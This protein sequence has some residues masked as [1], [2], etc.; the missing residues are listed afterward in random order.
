LTPAKLRPILPDCFIIRQRAGA[1]PAKNRELQEKPLTNVNKSGLPTIL[2]HPEGLFVLFFTEMWER[3]SYYGMRALLVLF[4]VST[5]TKGGWGWE[6]KDALELYGNYAFLVYI[7]PIVGGWIADQF[8][9]S[10]RSVVIGGFIIAAG[11]ICLTLETVATFYTGLGLIVLGTGLFKPNISAIVGQLYDKADAAGR[12]AGYTLFYMGINA[13]AFFGILLCGYIGE[14]IKWSYGFGL[15]GFFMILGALQF[16]LSQGVFGNIGLSKEQTAV[17]NVAH[18]EG[19]AHVVRDRLIAIGIFAFFTIFFWMAFEQAGGSMTIFAAD[20]TDRVLTGNFGTAFKV[21]NM[22]MT[23]IPTMVLSWLL[24]KLVRITY[25][26]F[27]L[28]NLALILALSTIWGLEIWML[29]RDFAADTSTVAAT[30]FGTLNSFFIV[31][32]APLFSKMWEEYWKPSAPVKFGVGLILLG[33]G[34]GVLAYGA[35]GIPSGAKTA[36]V[37]MIYLVLAYWLHTMGELC[38]SP[39]G[40]SLVSKLAPP[41]LLGLMFGIWFIMTAIAEKLAGKTGGMIDEISHTYSLS[42]FFLIFTAIPIGAGIILMVLNGPIKR[43]MHG[44]E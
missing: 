14:N 5:A 9:G 44:V 25:G 38:V 33:L 23:V 18:D 27:L 3:F 2:G 31:V 16:Y 36:S 26:R 13:G 19:E 6:R 22:L 43:L 29:W 37:S 20:Y 35:A 34:F 15:A 32:L 17:N 21:F 1:C 41:R 8:L 11:H 40:L 7:T 10:R 42:T 24:I 39:V 12:D 4:L 28:A 30:W